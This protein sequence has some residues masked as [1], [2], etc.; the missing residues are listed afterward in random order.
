M[1]AKFSTKVDAF[2]KKV[3]ARLRVI[4]LESVQETVSLA[5]RTR[6]E[7]GRMRVATGFLRASVQGAIEQM[8]S[9]P[10]DNPE[11]KEYPKD[12]VVAGEPVVVTLLHWDPIKEETFF[13]GWTAN[14]ARHRETL[15]GFLRGAVEL[16]DQTVN[17]AVKKAE[18]RIG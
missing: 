8:P 6:G 2:A 4:A 9:G 13:V 10:T 12:A 18:H 3:E 17:K 7:G 16:W 15:D 5:Q 1:T 14:Y 11:K